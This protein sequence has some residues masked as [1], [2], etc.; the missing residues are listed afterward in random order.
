VVAATATEG[1]KERKGEAAAAAV[2]GNK[3]IEG[4][5]EAAAARVIPVT[6]VQTAGTAALNPNP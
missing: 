2:E 1:S 4:E 3:E 6:E 5:E